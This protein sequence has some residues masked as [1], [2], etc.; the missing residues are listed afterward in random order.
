MGRENEGGDLKH[1]EAKT[2]LETTVDLEDLGAGYDLEEKKV[3]RAVQIYEE[4]LL[5]YIQENRSLFKSTNFLS[6][7]GY[8]TNLSGIKHSSSDGKATAGYEDDE[9]YTNTKRHRHD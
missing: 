9:R 7:R 5:P 4:K 6:I 8:A 1:E 3:A 2:R